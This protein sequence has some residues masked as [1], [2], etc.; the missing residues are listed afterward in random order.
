LRVDEIRLPGKP[1]LH[2]VRELLEVGLVDSTTTGEY[3][4]GKIC[5][6]IVGQIERDIPVLVLQH[7]RCVSAA[8]R[9][10]RLGL[11]GGVSFVEDGPQLVHFP[12]PLEQIHPRLRRPL[13]PP[14]RLV[15]YEWSRL[16]RQLHVLLE[17][18]PTQPPLDLSNPRGS[19]IV[20]QMR[21]PARAL[22]RKVEHLLRRQPRRQQKAKHAVQR[23]ANDRDGQSVNRR[24]LHQTP[25]SAN[26]RG[27]V[28]VR[29]DLRE[30]V[31]AAA[32]VIS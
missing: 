26:K 18:S 21:H 25:K 10:W 19:L 6:R 15:K 32:P 8:R 28:R 20:R 16:L 24:S 27:E 2:E 4:S 31:L 13:V 11:E 14:V 17:R 22:E 23:R 5:V 29:R 3:Y 1:A 30:E 9:Q 7:Q 12:D